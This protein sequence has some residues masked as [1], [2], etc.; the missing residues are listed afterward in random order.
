MNKI[1][2]HFLKLGRIFYFRKMT[3]EK[4]GTI[5]EMSQ[6]YEIEP[7]IFVKATLSYVTN[8]LDNMCVRAHSFN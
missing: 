2:K 5:V 7:A 6:L 8:A 1:R 4:N 3:D